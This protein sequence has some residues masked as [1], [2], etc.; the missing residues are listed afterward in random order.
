MTRKWLCL[1]TLQQIQK[2]KLTF[3]IFQHHFFIVPTRPYWKGN[4]KP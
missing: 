2:D 3:Q 1:K 4:P